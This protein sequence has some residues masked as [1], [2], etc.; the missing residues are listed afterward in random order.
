[1]RK[2]IGI[3]MLLLALLLVPVIF[4]V[5]NNSIRNAEEEYR[6]IN[7]IDKN[8]FGTVMTLSTE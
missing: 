5:H 6:I 4:L 1:M 8:W 3:A 7:L 2:K